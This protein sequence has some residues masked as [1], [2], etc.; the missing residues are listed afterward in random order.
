V[1]RRLES[2]FVL[3]GALAGLAATLIYL[4]PVLASGQTQPAVYWVAHGLKVLGGAAGGMFM[5]RRTARA[6][7]GARATV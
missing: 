7:T 5:A 6:G 3:H 1:C 2:R 4:V